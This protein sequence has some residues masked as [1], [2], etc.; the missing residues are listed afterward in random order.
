MQ[1][2]KLIVVIP[3]FNEAKAISS[4]VPD[5]HQNYVDEIIVVD[6]GSTD[7]TGE[8]ARKLGCVVISEPKKGY[9]N[10]L[11]RGMREALAHGA[12]IVMLTEADA[13]FVAKDG[14]KLLAYID[15]ADLIFGSRATLELVSP[16]SK[17]DRFLHYGNLFIAKSLQVCWWGR[18]R[19]TDV[20]CTLRIIKREALLQII[21]N[22]TEG[23][24]AFLIDLVSEA[25]RANLKCV[26]IPVHYKERIGESKIT[27][28]RRK[29]INVGFRMLRLILSKRLRSKRGKE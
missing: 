12:D 1:K 25:L 14:Y 18:L 10:A 7:G 6:N 3:A 20:G 4:T 13:T 29:S 26:E 15:D 8:L 23:G 16:G 5:F 9:G 19:I 11:M 28:G 2:P 24:S 22:F 27:T 21:D 17:W